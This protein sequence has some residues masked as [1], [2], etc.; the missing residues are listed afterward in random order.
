METLEVKHTPEANAR[1]IAAAPELLAELKEAHQIIG[2]LLN[3]LTV[4]QKVEL[5]KLDT[6]DGAV[7]YHPRRAAIEKAEGA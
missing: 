3:L 5:A 6:G 2:A 1:L 7:R 4:D